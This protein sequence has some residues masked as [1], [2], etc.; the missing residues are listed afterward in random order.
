MNLE[1]L[2]KNKGWRVQLVPIASRLDD[3]GGELPGATSLKMQSW[4]ESSS[5]HSILRC[6]SI[7]SLSRS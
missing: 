4:S 1:Q 7:R 3:D 6:F 2:K 5:A